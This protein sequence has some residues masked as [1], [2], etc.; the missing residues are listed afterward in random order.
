MGEKMLQSLGAAANVVQ[1]IAK[2]VTLKG[3]LKRIAAFLEN[4][5]YALPSPPK[6][7]DRSEEGDTHLVRGWL[8]TV[9]YAVIDQAGRKVYHYCEN[10]VDHIML[11]RIQR[12]QEWALEYLSSVPRILKTGKIIAE[13]PNRVIYESRRTYKSP[14]GGRCSL[15]VI[16][17][18]SW[19]GRWYVATF[20]PRYPKR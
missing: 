6:G 15:R 18:R 8:M 4:E 7:V 5:G 17:R 13:E 14:G 1:W 11:R 20:Y 3:R 2:E 9:E 16:V 12:G 19:E 10:E